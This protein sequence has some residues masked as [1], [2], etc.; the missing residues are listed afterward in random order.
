MTCVCNLYSLVTNGTGSILWCQHQDPRTKQKTRR[1]ERVSLTLLSSLGLSLSM[2]KKDVGLP[3]ACGV[4]ETS[5]V[6]T[7]YPW[8]TWS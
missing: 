5:R 4:G 2:G 3:S 1:G 6:L 8:R 7:L